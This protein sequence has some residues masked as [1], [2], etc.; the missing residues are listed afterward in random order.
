MK[1]VFTFTIF[2]SFDEKLGGLL[3]ESLPPDL[4]NC[5]L[6][7]FRGSSCSIT[8]SFSSRKFTPTNGL[9]GQMFGI[10]KKFFDMVIKTDLFVSRGHLW[11]YTFLFHEIFKLFSCFQTLRKT[12]RI[13]GDKNF[14]GLSKLFSSV[15]GI[16]LEE[17][18]FENK[19]F[20]SFLYFWTSGVIFSDFRR[21]FFDSF[22]KTAF[23]VYSGDFWLDCFFYKNL[24]VFLPSSGCEE[25][26]LAF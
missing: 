13:S 25:N 21:K 26:I 3:S 11:R 5:F 10:S 1:K 6:H 22:L 20:E 2:S 17:L 23:Y 18:I 12:F 19:F 14:V 16:F 7:S 9:W 4:K 24:W 8:S 15:Q